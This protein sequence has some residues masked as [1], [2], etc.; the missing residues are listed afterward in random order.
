MH[1]RAGQSYH[2][3]GLAIDVVEISNGAAIWNTNWSGLSRK[4]YISQSVLRREERFSY[5][6]WRGLSWKYEREDKSFPQGMPNTWEYSY[7]Y[8][9]M[10]ERES[11]RCLLDKILTFYEQN[12]QDFE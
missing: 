7:R 11:K 2:N 4:H 8:N 10:G 12:P 5:S 1:A 9:A 6:S 3:Y